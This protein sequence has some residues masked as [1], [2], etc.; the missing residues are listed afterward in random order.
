MYSLTSELNDACAS[1]TEQ[2]AL[3]PEIAL[4]LGS[5]LGFFAEEINQTQVIPYTEIPHFPQ[6]TV[7]GHAGQLVFG[8]WEGKT[9]V[10]AQ[11]RQ[12]HYEGYSLDEVTFATR[13]FHEMGARALIITN[14]AGCA[15]PEYAPGEFM[16]I[17]RHFPMVSSMLDEPYDEIEPRKVWDSESA[18]KL[19]E[20]SAQENIVLR[21]GTY[22]WVTGPS[23]ET[24]SEVEY[25]RHRGGDAIGMSTVPEAITA[26]SLGMKVLGISCFTNYATGL[27]DTVLSHAEVSATAESVKHN[28][29][30]LVKSA[31]TLF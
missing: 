29:A 16:T 21:D 7:E 2:Y 31:I 11:G 20:I 24:K 13:L 9:L 3:A 30:T 1:I 23:Y 10:I 12:H 8:N 18:T 25:I 22:A 6:S 15:N 19:R 17:T 28:F 26:A 27:S 5:G 14:A 4:T